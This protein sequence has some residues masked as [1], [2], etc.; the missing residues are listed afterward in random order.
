MAQLT[1]WLKLMVAEIQRKREE[2]D[3]AR[4]EE[5]AR[6][7]ETQKKEAPKGKPAARSVA[8]S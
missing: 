8:M 2:E 3:R 5:L 1:E 4:E 6:L 7:N